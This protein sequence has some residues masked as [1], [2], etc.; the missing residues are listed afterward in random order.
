MLIPLGLPEKVAMQEALCCNEVTARYGLVLKQAEAA[1]LAETR[2]DAL[3]KSGRVEFGGGV[4]QSLIMAFCDSPYIV[5]DTWADTL[6]E[7]TCIFYDFKTNSLDEVDDAE[8][9]S[10]MRRAF[11]EW[12]G[13]LEMV[14][15]AM[16]AA[17]RNVRFGRAPEDDGE[18]DED[19]E[20]DETNE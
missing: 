8:A 6:S 18:D 14:E 2:R 20:E 7:L 13:A 1:A 15:K 19:T 5:R 17:A 3:V 11:D 10:L 12:R 16:E 9:I 4:M